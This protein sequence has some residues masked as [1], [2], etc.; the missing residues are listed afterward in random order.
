VTTLLRR[1]L[2]VVADAMIGWHQGG[3]SRHLAAE[4]RWRK[5]LGRWRDRPDF[6][7]SF[8]RRDGTP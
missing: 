2:A 8:P 3:S 6:T 5:R 7:I 1:A 4:R